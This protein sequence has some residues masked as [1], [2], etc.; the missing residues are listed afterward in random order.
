VA[1]LDLREQHEGRG[2]RSVR[3]WSRICPGRRVRARCHRL[4][5]DV[6]IRRVILDLVDAIAKSV[7]SVQLRL[8]SIGALGILL[9]FGR[10]DP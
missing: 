1:R 8:D 2:T 7:V 4:L 10:A 5:D 6:M 9:E 3:A